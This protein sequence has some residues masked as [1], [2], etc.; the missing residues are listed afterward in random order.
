M[1]LVLLGDPVAHSLSPAI[2]TA[3][4][5]ACGIDG[6]YEA[7]RVDE[8][9]LRRA[10]DEIRYG[11]LHG[12]NVTMPHKHLAFSVSD[13]LSEDAMRTGAVN[14]LVGVPG[15][16]R[17]HNT[18]VAGVR[19]AWRHASLPQAPVLI[20]GAGGAAAAA[21]VALAGGEITVSARDRSAAEG[22][23]ERTRVRGAVVEWGYPVAGAVVVNATPLGMHGERLPNDLLA[24]AA[25]LLEMPYASG[26]TAAEADAAALGLPVSSG[27]DMLL[28]QA[29][30][31]FTLWTGVEAPEAVMREAM[32]AARRSQAPR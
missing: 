21:A 26:T 6:H 1:R 11:A 27:A 29:I 32:E 19:Y 8:A 23:L 5:A 16:A 7:R 14:T 2:H 20:L 3:A 28:G 10:L 24:D 9:G 12:A 18:D 30:A 17:G 15:G 13:T 22:L 25:G 31:A 4:L